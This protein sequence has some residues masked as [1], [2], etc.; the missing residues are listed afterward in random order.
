MSNNTILQNADE[1]GYSNK[2]LTYKVIKLT[3]TEDED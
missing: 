1:S 2:D 3:V